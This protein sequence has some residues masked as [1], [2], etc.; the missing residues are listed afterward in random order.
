V[1]GR[2]RSRVIS[3]ELEASLIYKA[4]SRTARTN[5]RNSILKSKNKQKNSVENADSYL[6]LKLSLVM[7]KLYINMVWVMSAFLEMI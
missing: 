2:Q 7:C 6:F 4:S 1:P 5:K 3:C